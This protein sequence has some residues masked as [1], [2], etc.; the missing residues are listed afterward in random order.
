MRTELTRVWRRRLSV[1][2]LVLAVGLCAMSVAGRW[3]LADLS[4]HTLS[5][6]REPIASYRV[7]LTGIPFS[8]FVRQDATPC[9]QA[10][11]KIS[12][13]TPDSKDRE[14]AQRLR[15]FIS[16][17]CEAPER[18]VERFDDDLARGAQPAVSDVLTISALLDGMG[19]FEKAQA[20]RKRMPTVSVYYSELGRMFM[21][22]KEDTGRAFAFFRLAQQIDPTF[23]A[24]KI[25]MYRHLCLALLRG[26]ETAVPPDSC[27]TFDRAIGSSLSRLLLGQNQFAQGQY[28]EAI[29]SLNS[30][31][32]MNRDWGVSYYWLAKSLAAIGNL[33]AARQAYRAGMAHDETYPWNYI[34]LAEIDTQYGC[35]DA[36]RALLQTAAQLGDDAARTSA[37]GLLLAIE[38]KV[39]NRNACGALPG[40]Q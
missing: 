39:N 5:V 21:E 19:Q 8:G 29:V 22:E 40:E 16:F 33:S 25:N 1:W 28:E 17:S 11:A 26:N 30:S 4:L 23:D 14:S 10:L 18:I 24:R 37:K 27:E 31:L 3:R 7:N 35:H 32:S 2:A 12:S 34:G 36:A 13:G 20:L 38:G 9:N 15:R 6:L